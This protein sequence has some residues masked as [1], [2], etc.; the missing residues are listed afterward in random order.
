MEPLDPNDERFSYGNDSPPWMNA[1]PE[2]PPSHW[3]K[4]M[5]DRTNSD[6]YA[7][8]VAGA[9]KKNQEKTDGRR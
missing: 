4:V 7:K 9:R 5:T 3:G 8:F 2:P 6:A 1:V